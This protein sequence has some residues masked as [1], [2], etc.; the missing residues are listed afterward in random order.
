MVS[1]AD[2]RDMLALEL[3][4]AGPKMIEDLYDEAG[5]TGYLQELE[6][7]KWIRSEHTVLTQAERAERGWFDGHPPIYEW[8]YFITFKGR[9]ALFKMRARK[10]GLLPQFGKPAN[11]PS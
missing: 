5:Y 7:V 3:L 9:W 2:E 10:A 8:R 6:D 11:G 1:Y 4:E